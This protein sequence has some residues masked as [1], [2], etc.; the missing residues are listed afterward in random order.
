MMLSLLS[1]TS[2]SLPPSLPFS[3]V[4]LS[5]PLLL[6]PL[7]NRFFAGHLKSNERFEAALQ[8]KSLCGGLSAKTVSGN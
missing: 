2:L 5:S 6:S 1:S 3:F 4:F 7:V 8:L